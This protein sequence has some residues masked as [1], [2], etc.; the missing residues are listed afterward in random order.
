VQKRRKMDTLEN[1]CLDVLATLLELNDEEHDNSFNVIHALS[2]PL[3][4]ALFN[5]LTKFNRSTLRH[6]C[7]SSFLLCLN[8]S[9]SRI[10]N[11]VRYCGSGI[12]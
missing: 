5:R 10:T 4:C 7:S 9:N 6:F 1:M 12:K 3:C 11:E 8:L 2:N